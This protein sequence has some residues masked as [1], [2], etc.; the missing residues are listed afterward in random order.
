MITTLVSLTVAVVG[1][2]GLIWW[3]WNDPAVLAKVAEYKRQQHND[4]DNA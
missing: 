1:N 4:D 3:K 2:S